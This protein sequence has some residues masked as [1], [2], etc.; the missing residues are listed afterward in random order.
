MAKKESVYKLI[1]V[2]GLISLIP[3]TLVAG[4][5]SGY[6][7]GDFLRVKFGLP[8][9]ALVLFVA[10]GIAGSIFETV[11]IIKAALFAEETK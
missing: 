5:L 8:Y 4:P 10:I 2:V 1:R 9:F 3:I 7:A 11:R 6:I